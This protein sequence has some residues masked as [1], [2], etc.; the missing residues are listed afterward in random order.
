VTQNKVRSP[1]TYLSHTSRPIF[2]E[3]SEKLVRQTQTLQLQND[4][5]IETILIS[6][7]GRGSEVLIL[8][9]LKTEEDQRKNRELEWIGRTLF[10]QAGFLM[11]ICIVWIKAGNDRAMG[12]LSRLRCVCNINKIQVI[13]LKPRFSF[14]ESAQPDL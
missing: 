10:S 5:V 8:K 6:N 7:L 14:H 3:E 12:Y 4:K 9:L 13:E 11:P 2:G 1:I